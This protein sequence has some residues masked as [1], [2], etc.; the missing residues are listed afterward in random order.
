MIEWLPVAALDER[1]AR[2]APIGV[3]MRAWFHA[4]S[5]EWPGAYIEHVPEIRE[6]DGLGAEIWAG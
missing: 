6:E 4:R 5:Q 3:R 2:Y 1:L